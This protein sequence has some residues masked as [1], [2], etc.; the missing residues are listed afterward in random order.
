MAAIA[1]YN[2]QRIPRRIRRRL[3]IRDGLHGRAWV[4]CITGGLSVLEITDYLHLWATVDGIQL[5]DQ[6][7]RVIWRWTEDGR[8]SAKSAYSMMHAGS[9]VMPG[10]RLIWKTW[11]PLW[12]KI[13]LWLAMKRRH[14]TGDRRARHGLETREPCYLC[15]QGTE[16]IDHIIA[17][18]PFSRE[19]WF[20]FLRALRRPLLSLAATSRAWWR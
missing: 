12:V 11:A 6:P 4:R 14:W 2:H 9:I 20:Y 10:Y 1:P 3:T 19:V 18:C 8:Y 5:H 15:D 17:A 13:F 16:T 7:D